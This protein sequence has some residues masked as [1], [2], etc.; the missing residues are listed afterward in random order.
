MSGNSW[1]EEAEQAKA[2]YRET[3]DRAV[4]AEREVK[5]LREACRLALSRFD[6]LNGKVSPEV[7]KGDCNAV[8]ALEDALRGE[9]GVR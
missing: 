9:E 3:L 4:A 2:L 7:W 5:R 1:L 8:E 6:N